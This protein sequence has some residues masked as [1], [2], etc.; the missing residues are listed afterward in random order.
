MNLANQLTIFRIVVIP[1]LV[2][3]FYWPV[4]WAGYAVVS[5]FIVAALSDWFDGYIARRL[6]QT[7]GFGAFLDPVADKLIVA[8]VLILLTEEVGSW[9]LT[10]AAL[11]IIGREIT[12]S[13]LREWMSSLGK[14][15]LVRVTFVAKIKT[16]V[17]MTAIVFLLLAQKT[18]LSLP[19]IDLFVVGLFLLYLAV[20]L[21]LVS[22]LIYVFLIAK[23]S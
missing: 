1:L 21:T 17:Q 3:F 14:E 8:V 5:L 15:K 4:S 13:G 9:P 12:V 11:V 7:T 19:G 16:V 22:M 20:V 6:Q 23:S 2:F 18:T 10:V